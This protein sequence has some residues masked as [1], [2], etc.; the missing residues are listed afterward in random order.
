LA[1]KDSW[2]N[3]I[4][5]SALMSF[6]WGYLLYTGNISTIWPLFGTANQTLATIAFAIGTTVII[7]MGKQKYAPITIIPMALTAITTLT[8]IITN[9]F[10]N[11]LPKHQNLLAALSAVLII[12]MVIIVAESI[13]V[14][15]K[16]SKKHSS[17]NTQNTNNAI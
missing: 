8:A 4:F 15:I 10:S 1:K 7:K 3:I 14:W 6:T 17:S 9:I 12:M 11:Y 16:E 13:K 5:F 2:G